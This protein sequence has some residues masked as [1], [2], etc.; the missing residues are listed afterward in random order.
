MK[1]V[2]IDWVDSDSFRGIWTGVEVIKEHNTL[3]NCRSIGW[4]INDNKEAK[5]IVS[6]IAFDKKGDI[7]QCA[8]DMTIPVGAIRKITVLPGKF[9][10]KK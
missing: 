6:H 7:N 4:L 1:L 3:P 10:M 5:T 2:Q 9:G 8:G